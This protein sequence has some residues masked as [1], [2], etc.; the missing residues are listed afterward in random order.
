M[1]R[2]ILISAWEIIS[3]LGYKTETTEIDELIKLFYANAK[4]FAR[5]KIEKKVIGMSLISFTFCILGIENIKEKKERAIQLT[6]AFA[7]EFLELDEI[8]HFSVELL[9]T[10]VSFEG[11]YHNLSL[12]V[13]GKIDQEVIQFAHKSMDISLN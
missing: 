6:I 11:I 8:L 13:S 2:I 1:N 12:V 4:Q 9:K 7:N 10:K 3:L 5:T